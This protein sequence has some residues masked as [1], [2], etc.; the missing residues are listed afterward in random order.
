MNHPVTDRIAPLEAP[1]SP[2]VAEELARWQPGE[3]EP[4]ALFRTIMRHLPLAHAM[5]PLGHYFLSRESSLALRD[6]EI[7]IDRVCARRGCEYEWGVHARI[8]AEGAGLDEAQLR[9]SVAGTA[10][11]ACWSD[12]DRMLIRMVDALHDT[13]HIDDGLWAAMAERWT[14]AQLLD[15][16]ALAGWYHVISFL[17]NG[18]RVP[19]EQW[20]PRFPASE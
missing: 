17:A 2:E 16:L 13:G 7:V 3:L 9:A 15:L 18:A 5:Y 11:D 19:L 1:F 4:I 12:S 14:H 6:R 20:A 8:F 10:N